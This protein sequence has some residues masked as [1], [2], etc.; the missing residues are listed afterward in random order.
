[1]GRW[2]KI[3]S[4]KGRP[5]SHSAPLA[6]CRRGND[7]AGRSIPPRGLRERR[8]HRYPW[9]DMESPTPRVVIYAAKSTED[10]RGSIPDQIAECQRFAAE[11]GWIIDATYQDVG[12]SAYTG[13]RGPELGQA[14]AHASRFAKD[15]G[16][17]ILLVW[18]SDRLARGAG[19]TRDAALHLAEVF[20]EMRRA[21]VRIHS[22]TDDATFTSPLLAVTMGERN[23]EDSKRKS[24]G[25]K[26]GARRRAKRGEYHGG[27]EPYGFRYAFDTR[28]GERRLEILEAEAVVVRR[29]FAEAYAGKSQRSIARDLNRE[30]I[31]TK[32]DKRWTQPTISKILRNSIYKGFVHLNGQIYPGEHPAI[33]PPSEWDRV[34]RLLEATART[35]GGGRGRLPKRH[36]LV[37]GMLKCGCCGA[38]MVP[39]TIR[40]RSQSGKAYE[41]YLCSTHVSDKNACPQTPVAREVIDSSI[42][43]YFESEFF[44][45]EATRVFVA[46]SA[47]RTLAEVRVLREQAETDEREASEALQRVRR[48]YARGALPAED[49]LELKGELGEELA[50]ARA[51]ATRFRDREV[52]VQDEGAALVDDKFVQA[53]AELRAVIAGRVNQARGLDQVRSTI[54]TL[55]ECFVYHDDHPRNS[56][57]TRD[58]V[59]EWQERPNVLLAL[60]NPD[61]RRGYLE[62][63]VRP[64][65]VEGYRQSQ[66]LLAD[67]VEE[68]ELTDE[69]ALQAATVPVYHRVPLSLSSDNKDP[70]GF[71]T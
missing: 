61:C 41:A 28:T 11:Q 21:S 63:V 33:V 3:R 31:P 71:T 44:D 32:A 35:T 50:G 69:E 53:L 27:P 16:E 40:P 20:F 57:L 23:F 26:A 49:W 9:W 24:A 39:R 43:S 55:F 15:H 36:L 47:E 56:Q 7:L 22:V 6:W 54:L 65:V 13:N 14:K 8:G 60:S 45:V 38:S 1:M 51:K 5:S 25:V 2:R 67:L 29:I 58:T 42:F 18:H 30:R 48:D 37:R 4:G 12:F 68:F 62:P 59:P 64:S 19:D 46:E 34:S 52:E 70:M 17:A 10:R 66:Q